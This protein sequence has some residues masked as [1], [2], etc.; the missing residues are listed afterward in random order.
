A[1]ALGRR[2]QWLWRKAA[3]WLWWRAARARR[4]LRAHQTGRLR[5]AAGPGRQRR[6]QPVGSPR[7]ARR[8]TGWRAGAH[9]RAGWGPLVANRL[10][11]LLEVRGW[12]PSLGLRTQ[13][14]GQATGLW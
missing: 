3:D 5:P 4:A 9:L 13:P 7:A 12:R 2:Q 1:P 14:I 11:G 10:R 6:R 8:E